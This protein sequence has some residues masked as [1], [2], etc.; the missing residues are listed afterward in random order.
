MAGGGMVTKTLPPPTYL[1]LVCCCHRMG[2]VTV[3]AKQHHTC[4]DYGC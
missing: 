1:H 2:I 4:G 3:A